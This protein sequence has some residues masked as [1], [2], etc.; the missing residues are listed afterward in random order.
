MPALEL[1]PHGQGRAQQS[2]QAPTQS[3]SDYWLRVTNPGKNETHLGNLEG[4][5][6]KNKGVSSEGGV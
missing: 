1:A 3:P 2:S 5:L 6:D 4:A